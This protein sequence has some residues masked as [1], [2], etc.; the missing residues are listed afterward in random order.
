MALI[1][2]AVE[3]A[4]KAKADL[5]TTPF[6]CSSLI[7]LS[8]GTVNYIYCGQLIRPLADGTQK[9]LVKHGEDFAALQPSFKLPTSRCVRNL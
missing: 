9:V 5:D 8:G 1:V 3:I 6:A 2:D 7:P 4:S